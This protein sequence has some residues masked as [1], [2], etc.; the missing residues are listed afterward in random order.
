M[1]TQDNH[2]YT[3]V[4]QSVSKAE[5][6]DWT[7]MWW[8]GQSDAWTTDAQFDASRKDES[9]PFKLVIGGNEY[10]IMR[11]AAFGEGDQQHVIFG[12]SK[13]KDLKTGSVVAHSDYTVCAAVYDEEAGQKDGAVAPDAAA[14][15]CLQGLR[16]LDCSV[17][18]TRKTC[19]SWPP[20]SRCLCNA[21]GGRRAVTSHSSCRAL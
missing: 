2:A 14:D 3:E 9:N 1:G 12:R 10:R 8:D 6:A 21:A 16:L 18:R 4:S 15:D 19:V 17:Q 20:L 11:R 5:I 7:R 13:N